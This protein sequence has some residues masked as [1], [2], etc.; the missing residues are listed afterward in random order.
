MFSRKLMGAVSAMVSIVALILGAA[1]I[2]SVSQE[3]IAIGVA[4]IAS[5]GGIQGIAQAAIDMRKA[6]TVD[7]ATL[8]QV[9][10]LT[11]SINQLKQSV[12]APTE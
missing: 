5:L 2:G 11:A 9:N 7:P 4:A 12:E 10:N 3:Q 1:Q 8:A 6:K